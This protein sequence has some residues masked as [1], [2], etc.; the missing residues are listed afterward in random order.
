[1]NIYRVV[2]KDYVDYDQYNGFVCVAESEEQAIHM[3]P[4]CDIFC[5]GIS[6]YYDFEKPDSMWV[7]NVSDLEV[8]CIGT[9]SLFDKPQ[10]ILTDFR[11][12]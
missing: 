7:S 4:N 12:G 11:A 2:R 8:E 3:N 5:Y 9:T 10:I 1:M 6:L